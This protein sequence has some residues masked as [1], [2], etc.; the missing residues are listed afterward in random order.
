MNVVMLYDQYI[1]TI[2]LKKINFIIKY[3]VIMDKLHKI[4]LSQKY[5]DDKI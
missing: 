3:C 2:N 4:N 1:V 5:V